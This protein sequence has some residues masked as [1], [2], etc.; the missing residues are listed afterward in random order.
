MFFDNHIKANKDKCYFT[1]SKNE[2]VSIKLDNTEIQNN[3]S[4]RI[5]GR[6]K[7]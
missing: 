2:Y 1:V 5:I 7:D 4:E 6:N 3:N